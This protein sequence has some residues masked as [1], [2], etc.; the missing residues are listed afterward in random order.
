MSGYPCGGTNPQTGQ[1]EPCD[2][3]NRP[4][5]RPGNLATRAQASKRV[6]NTFFPNCVTPGGPID[7]S[8]DADQPNKNMLR[9]AKPVPP[10]KPAS[11]D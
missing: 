3:A 5:F 7:A 11:N 10:A 8:S 1:A 4:Y 6:A 9:A 2:S